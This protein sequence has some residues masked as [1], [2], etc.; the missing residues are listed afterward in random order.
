MSDFTQSLIRAHYVRL[1]FRDY[2]TN[3]RII[4]AKRR[5]RKGSRMLGLAVS[6]RCEAAYSHIV[7][8]KYTATTD[9]RWCYF[10]N[11]PKRASTV[12][13]RLVS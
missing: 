7:Y 4:Q 3:L 6:A 10:F 11:Q 1:P 12:I 2:P 5:K 13:S 8:V 9:W